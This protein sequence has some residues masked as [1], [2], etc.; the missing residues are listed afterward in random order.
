VITHGHRSPYLGREL[1]TVE[2]A[3]PPVGDP[4]GRPANPAATALANRYGIPASL[5]GP[6][7]VTG[8]DPEAGVA[9]P[10]TPEQI[11]TI[12]RQATTATNQPF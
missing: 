2:Y 7:V 4:T 12:R 9:T 5:H 10:L 11:T 1:A 3:T 6:I 8:T